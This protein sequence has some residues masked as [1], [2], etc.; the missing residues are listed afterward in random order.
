MVASI[1]CSLVSLMW[2]LLLICFILYIFGILIMQGIDSHISSKGLSAV[3]PV[4]L[5]RFGSVMDAMLSLFMAV[6]GG[7]DW[8]E[9]LIPFRDL[10]PLF[11]LFVC[12]FMVFVVLGVMNILTAIFVES[13]GQVAA[14]DRDLVI[15][16]EL[17]RDSSTTT[18]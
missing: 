1:I 5:K 9:M 18:K 3:D 7:F 15:Q 14:I 17:A 12:F 13:A 16:S 8:E 2:A 11:I 6:T 4:L 10:S